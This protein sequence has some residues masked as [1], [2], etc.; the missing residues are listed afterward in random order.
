[1]LIASVISIA[2]FFNF[3]GPAAQACSTF[4]ALSI[5][6][7]ASPILALLTKGTYDIARAPHDHAGTHHD[8]AACTSCG[9]E[10]AKEDMACCP[11]GKGAICSL[12]CSLDTTCRDICKTAIAGV[13]V[14]TAA[15]ICP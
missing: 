7:V 15:P 12:C 5:A 10:F 3:L 13:P 1:M 9:F 2:A 14:T 11:H 8:T 6:F 4:L